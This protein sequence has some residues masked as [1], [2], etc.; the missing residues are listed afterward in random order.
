MKGCSENTWRFLQNWLSTIH[1]SYTQDVAELAAIQK[2]IDDAMAKISAKTGKGGMIL[3]PFAI[4]RPGIGLVPVLALGAA[5][6]AALAYFNPP[7]A[8]A[9]WKGAVATGATAGKYAVTAG[10]TVG[11]YASSG[12]SAAARW[13]SRVRGA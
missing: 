8:A 11:S 3:R 6:A 5:G 2:Q 10:K 7:L 1:P 12:A 13:I 4:A 9:V